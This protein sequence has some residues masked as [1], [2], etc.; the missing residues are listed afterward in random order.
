MVTNH[1][2]R[3]YTNHALDQ[4]LE[5]LIETGINKIIRIG[6]QS[7]ST[8]LEG[9]NLRLVSKE[10][11]KTK[12]EGY[13]LARTYKAL[14]ASEESISRQLGYLH[15]AQKRLG[16]DSIRRYLASNYPRIHAQFARV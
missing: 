14:E 4:F 7:K 11:T 2:Y 12:S 16:W 3:C 8:I 10:E 6:G 1:G 5:H 9:K 15:S 13:L